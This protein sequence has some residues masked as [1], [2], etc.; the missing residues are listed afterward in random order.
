VKRKSFAKA[1][2]FVRNREWPG[3]RTAEEGG[4]ALLG[5]RAGPPARPAT[6]A[7]PSIAVA[8]SGRA[9]IPAEPRLLAQR[10]NLLDVY[11]VHG[12]YLGIF[13]EAFDRVMELEG[14]ELTP[15][16]QAPEVWEFSNPG[17]ALR[18]RLLNIAAYLHPGPVAL[19]TRGRA[20]L[21]TRQNF[22]LA[23]LL[24]GSP[25]RLHLNR[26]RY[27]PVALD[28]RLP[29]PEDWPRE[30]VSQVIRTRFRTVAILDEAFLLQQIGLRPPAGATG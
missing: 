15:V 8:T 10:K 25:W 30:L 21:I 16:A 17:A 19:T 1:C 20:Y 22:T 28:G 13:R 18:G 7:P 26:T 24:P 2:A 14:F 5:I 27:K 29:Y 12:V 9:C 4:R 23:L 6:A 11:L 3:T